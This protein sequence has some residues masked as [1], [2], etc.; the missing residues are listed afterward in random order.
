M[1]TATWRLIRP[2][3]QNLVEPQNEFVGDRV[4][5]LPY[6]SDV[7]V[8]VK[9]DFIEKFPREIFDGK[10]VR[11]GEWHNLVIRLCKL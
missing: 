2:I 4:P 6:G 8:L 3:D 10:F 5:T 11:K 1:E 9:H 7:Q